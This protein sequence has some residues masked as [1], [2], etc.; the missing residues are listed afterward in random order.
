MPVTPVMPGDAREPPP[1]MPV[2][3]VMPDDARGPTPAAPG[4]AQ[5]TSR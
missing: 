4:D 1:A 5:D 2:T 3:P